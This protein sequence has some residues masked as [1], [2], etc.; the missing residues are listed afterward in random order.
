M[1]F[2]ARLKKSNVKMEDMKKQST[3]TAVREELETE[4]KHETAK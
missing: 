2:K 1:A 3:A 4:R